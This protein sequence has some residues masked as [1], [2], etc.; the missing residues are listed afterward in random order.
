MPLLS[1]ICILQ[2]DIGTITKKQA[3][4]NSMK[5]FEDVIVTTQEELRDHKSEWEGKYIEYLH[6]SAINLDSIKNKRQKFHKWGPLSIYYTLGRAKDNSSYFDVRYQGQSVGQISVTSKGEVF[7]HISDI[8]YKNNCNEQYFSGYPKDI[9]RPGKYGWKTSKE[10]MAFRAFFKSDPGKKGHPEHRC[11]N[12]LLR[13]LSK[14][15][16]NNKSLCHIQPVTITKDLFFQMPTPISASGDKPYYSGGKGGIDILARRNGKLVV[17]ELKDQYSSNHETPTKVIKQAIAYAT[18]LVELC[19]TSACD[20]FWKLCGFKDTTHGN[21]TINVSVLL[22]DPGKEEKELSFA[23]QEL[24]VPKSKM[25]IMLHYTFFRI[26]G[27]TA[28]ITRTTL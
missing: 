23:N 22:P 16:S 11:E 21:E 26:E 3:M 8:Q 27:E 6:N 7:L 14:S 15:D 4:E 18:F 9:C 13:E 2:N 1:I 24:E 25:K 17:F 28:I 5:E 10:A 19:K 12:L 20:D